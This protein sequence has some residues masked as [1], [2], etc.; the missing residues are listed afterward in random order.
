MLNNLDI[1][2]LSLAE[3][4]TSAVSARFKIKMTE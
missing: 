4:K 2:E 3:A 1:L